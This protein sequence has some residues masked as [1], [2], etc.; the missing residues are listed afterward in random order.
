MCGEIIS[1]LL[2]LLIQQG[3]IFNVYETQAVAHL[4]AYTNM[5]ESQQIQPL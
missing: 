5:M 1:L 4:A 3:N 2:A